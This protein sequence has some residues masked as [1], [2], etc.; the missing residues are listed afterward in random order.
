MEQLK[1]DIERVISRLHEEARR[2]RSDTKIFAAIA[3]EYSH[4]IQAMREE[5]YSY[6][7]ICSAFEKEELLPEK[8]NIDSF[9]QACRRQLAK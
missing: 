7:E 9:R 1:E 6:I 2:S 5:G 8:T 3:R 4:Q